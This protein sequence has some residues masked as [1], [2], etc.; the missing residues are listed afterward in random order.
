MTERAPPSQ[1]P[2]VKSAS[3]QHETRMFTR[4]VLSVSVLTVAIGLAATALAVLGPDP[5]PEAQQSLFEAF[6][7]LFTLGA[8][9]LIGLIGGR[10]IKSFDKP[11]G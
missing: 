6:I 10:S 3:V 5:L 11:E 8:M 2:C 9:A 7:S 1:A 4:I